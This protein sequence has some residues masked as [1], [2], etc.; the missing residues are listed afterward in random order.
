MGAAAPALPN[1]HV[2]P[3][4]LARPHEGDAVKVEVRRLEQVSKNANANRSVTYS[5][6]NTHANRLF[7]NRSRL[8]PMLMG[9]QTAMPTDQLL[10]GLQKCRLQ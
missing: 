9:H 2:G 8:T 5:S 10:T 7:T 1:G 6:Q 3:S 4:G